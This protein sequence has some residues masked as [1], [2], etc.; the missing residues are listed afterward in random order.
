MFE[1]NSRSEWRNIREYVQYILTSSNNIFT[2]AIDH[3]NQ[4]KGLEKST[5]GLLV[6]WVGLDKASKLEVCLSNQQD[7]TSIKKITRSH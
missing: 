5:K 2:T 4:M 3:D 7:I 6:D 1:I